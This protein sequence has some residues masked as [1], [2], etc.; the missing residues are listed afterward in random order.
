MLLPAGDIE[1]RALAAE[2]EVAHARHLPLVIQEELMF[3][4]AVLR[5][6]VNARLQTLLLSQQELVN[7]LLHAIHERRPLA[8]F[9]NV[10]GGTGKTY[11]EHVASC[12]AF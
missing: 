4:V 8:A 3:D 7:T 6:D 1:H 9:V 5:N 2:L 12:S 11:D 10:P